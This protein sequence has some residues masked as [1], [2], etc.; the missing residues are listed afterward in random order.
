M[1][2]LLSPTIAK[3]LGSPVE[4]SL[5]GLLVEYGV[6]E[7]D[8]LLE[9]LSRLNRVFDHYK[10]E[11]TPDIRHGGLE[12]PRV[13][14][15]P[16]QDDLHA[17]LAHIASLESAEVEFKSSLHVDKKRLFHNPGKPISDYKSDDVLRSALKTVAAFANSSG[18]TMYIGVEDDGTLCGLSEDF[19][20]ANPK[21]SDYDGWDQNFRSLIGSRFSD[22]AALSAYVQTQLFEH[23]SK[24]FV[25][26]RVT[27]KRRLT[28]LKTGEAWELFVRAGTQTNSIPYCDIEQH[29]TLSRL[30]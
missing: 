13:L 9:G 24:Q 11:C 28:F 20:A 3:A 29:F 27:P 30:Y 17:V 19:A 2:P 15:V 10:V 6:A 8:G 5:R 12:D 18:G 21:R 23:D 25:R 1:Q 16:A 7:G 22:G 4:V 14:F 26:V